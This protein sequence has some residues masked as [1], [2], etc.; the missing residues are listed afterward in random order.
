MTTNSESEE[1]RRLVRERYG[2]RAKGSS[3]SPLSSL[4]AAAIPDVVAQRTP[5]VR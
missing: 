1:I 4:M 2:A 5:S 3:N